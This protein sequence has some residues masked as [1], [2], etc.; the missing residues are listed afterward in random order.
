[1]TSLHLLADRLLA[2]PQ[3]FRTLLTIV[4]DKDHCSPHYPRDSS[5]RTSHRYQIADA[6]IPYI[7]W[8]SAC[9]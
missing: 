1:M 4:S 7:K 2:Q 6:H 8:N 5:S 3:Y 9:I